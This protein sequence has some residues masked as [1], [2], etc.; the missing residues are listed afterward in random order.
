LNERQ[1]RLFAASQALAQ[2]P[3]G[4]V[5]I[6]R[7]LGLSPRTIER[8]IQELRQGVFPV[9][10]DRVRRPGGGRA[11]VEEADP[12]LVQA[13]ESMLQETTAGDPMSLLRWTSKSTRTLATELTRQGHRVSHTTV[14][15]L[16]HEQHYSLRGNVKDYEGPPHPQRDAQF[17]YLR[18]QAQQFLAAQQ[19]VI[20]VDTKKKEKVGEFKNTGRQWRRHD[21]VVNV[22]DFPSLAEGKAILYFYCSRLGPVNK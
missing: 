20:S 2:G 1:A 16:L 9:G 21:R 12:G 8:G 14:L 6:A 3:D 11:T 4:P 15:R 5:R 18:D 17:R 10:A 22:Y 7:V 19:P 13:L